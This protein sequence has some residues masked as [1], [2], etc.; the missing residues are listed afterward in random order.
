MSRFEEIYYEARSDKWFKVFAAF[1]RIFLAAVFIATGTVKILGQRFA[2]GLPHNNPLGHYFDALLLTGYYYTFI[3]IG[4]V[5]AAILLL[6][7]RTAL[8]GALFYFP[9]ITN[10]CVLTYATRF[11]GTR[12]NTIA[13]L[14]CL[15]LLLW[16]YDRLKHIL[17]SRQPKPTPPVIQKPLGK[18][19][20]L[21]FF[22]GVVATLVILIFGTFYLFEI[23]PGNDEEECRNQCAGSKNPAA[24]QTFCD[25][26]Y[27]EGQ[28]LDSCLAT[29]HKAKDIRK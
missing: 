26:I 15:F 4:Q 28:P 23:V 1:C 5:T 7:P 12:S 18:R 11:D 13:F 6:I 16:D 20:R 8:L 14:A 22:G 21:F 9:I 29:F 10:I 17:P 3:G 25:C 24:C 19:L 2:E 27:K